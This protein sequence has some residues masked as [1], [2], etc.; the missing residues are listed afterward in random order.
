MASVTVYSAEKVDELTDDAVVGA[1]IT[2]GHLIIS[3]RNGTSFDVGAVLSGLS[4]A[5]DTVKGLVELATDTETTTGTDSARAVTPLGLSALTGTETR[6]GLVEL[7]TTTEAS[8]GTDTSRVVTPAG[9]A[10]AVMLKNVN[11][12]T[13]VVEDPDES[14]FSIGGTLRSWWNEWR[15]LR[16]RNP[17]PTYADA[18]VRAVVMDG[19]FT[20]GNA[21]EIEDRRT[22]NSITSIWGVNWGTGRVTQQDCAVGMVYVLNASQTSADIPASLPAGTLVVK[23]SV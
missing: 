4:D 2:D 17:Y 20:G 9:L 15:A 21:L 16:G 7:A 6:R 11:R 12:A 1:S 3:F 23:K 22:T 18:L 5:S 13:V 19:D 14:Q 8:T 10:S